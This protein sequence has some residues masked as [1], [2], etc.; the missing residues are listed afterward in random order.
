MFPDNLPT[1]VDISVHSEAW[2]RLLW[3]AHSV[4]SVINVSPRHM[5]GEIVPVSSISER[6]F[7]KTLQSY[8]KK[9][10]VLVHITQMEQCSGLIRT[11][12]KRSCYVSK[13]NDFLHRWW[14]YNIGSNMTREEWYV[15]PLIWSMRVLLSSR[16]AL[17]WPMLCSASSSVSAAILFPREKCT[18]EKL[19]DSSFQN[20]P[21]DTRPFFHF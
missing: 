6:L 12:F 1:N 5:L 16:Q 9:L 3:T 14:A 19:M 13:A 8:V 4:I 10:K 18:E 11:R 21:N 17:I 15:L 20:T 2:S 7:E